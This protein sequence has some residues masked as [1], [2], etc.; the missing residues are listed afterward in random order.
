MIHSFL[1]EIF[2][3]TI[4][5][6]EYFLQNLGHQFLLSM[7]KLRVCK[8][9]VNLQSEL[10]LATYSLPYFTDYKTHLFLRIIASKIQVHLILEINTKMSSDR[11]K[12][13][14]RLKNGHT[15]DA[16]GNLSLP[17]NTG[18][19]WRQQCTDVTDSLLYSTAEEG[20][21]DLAEIF[22]FVSFHLYL[23]QRHSPT[24]RTMLSSVLGKSRSVPF[25]YLLITGQ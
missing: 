18:F 3:H 5:Q 21:C 17:G 9:E 1:L 7:E 2:F 8:V 16:V 20:H 13:P 23:S 25:P 19:N 11:F 12:I 14:A 24:G 15:F 10:V 6:R 4:L 22:I